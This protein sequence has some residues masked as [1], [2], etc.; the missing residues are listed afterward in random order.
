VNGPFAGKVEQPIVD[1][2]TN[3]RPMILVLCRTMNGNVRQLIKKLDSESQRSGDLASI[4]LF[5][6]KDR[7]TELSGTL[8]RFAKDEKINA[9][10]VSIWRDLKS[11]QKWEVAKEAEI[12]VILFNMKLE[13]VANFPYRKDELT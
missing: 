8:K 4:V 13:V 12:T 6:E 2:A 1:L 5:S 9:A 10:V 11:P 7:A 3:R